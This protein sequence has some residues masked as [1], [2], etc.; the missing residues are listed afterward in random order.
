VL[1]YPKMLYREGKELVWEGRQLATR[2]IANAEEE[3]KAI[4]DGWRSIETMLAAKV[5]VIEKKV[6]AK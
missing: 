3:A 2:I 6:K 4:S 5:E 1:E